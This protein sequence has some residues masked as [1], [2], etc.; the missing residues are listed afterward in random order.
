MKLRSANTAPQQYPET[1][2]EMLEQAQ[3]KTVQEKEQKEE[4]KRKWK[5]GWRRCM[6]KTPS[7]AIDFVSRIIFPMVLAI[8]LIIFF[9]KDESV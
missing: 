9:A 2:I 6:P 8:L 3:N 5:R 7:R 1:A 4:Q